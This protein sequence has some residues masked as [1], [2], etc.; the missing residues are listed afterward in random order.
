MPSLA[1]REISLFPLHTVL[2]P[3]GV[4]PLKIFEQR[5]LEL[6]KAC[7]RD[8]APFGACLIREGREVGTP[9]V[10]ETIGCLATIAEWEMPQ[11]GLFHLVTRGKQRFRIVQTRTAA[12]GLIS[13]DVEMLA[14]PPAPPEIDATCR[15]VLELI[16]GKAGAARFPAPIDLDDADWV[17]YRL[18]EILPIDLAEKQRLLEMDDAVL[19]FIHLRR[20]LGEQGIAP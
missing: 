3:G 4:L 2:F 17:S 16:I 7:L 6:T 18:A 15:K 5:Y 8:N 11:L 13:A 1:E 14:P 19:R 20:T 12:N 9:A 10:P